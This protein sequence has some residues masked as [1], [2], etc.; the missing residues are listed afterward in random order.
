MCVTLGHALLNCQPRPVQGRGFLFFKNIRRDIKN[1]KS[2]DGLNLY[3]GPGGRLQ[4]RQ[5]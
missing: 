5:I 2:L 4:S 3:A 1:F